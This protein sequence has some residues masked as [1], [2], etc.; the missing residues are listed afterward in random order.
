M[1]LKR[2]FDVVYPATTKD[3]FFKKFFDFCCLLYCI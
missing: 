2:L 3:S 1:I